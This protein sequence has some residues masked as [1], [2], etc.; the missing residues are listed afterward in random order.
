MLFY[1]QRKTYKM[2]KV[3]IKPGLPEQ[4]SEEQR[5]SRRKLWRALVVLLFFILMTAGVIFL[6]FSM[7]KAFF[8]HNRHFKLKKLE[9]INGSF[10]HGKEKSL[11]YRT[12]VYP[13]VNLFSVDYA[14]FRKRIESIS[15]IEKAEV[16]RILPDKLQVKITE[17]I[18][19]AVL[20]TPAGR[21]VVDEQAVVIPRAESAVHGTLPV[22]TSVPGRR[23]VRQGETLETLRPAIE[24]IM[25]TLRNFP[26][27]DIEC[28]MP[29][30]S[31]G[32]TFFMRYRSGKRYHVTLPLNSKG[33]PYLLSALQT[34]IINIHW[35]QLN[36]SR[37]NLLY[38]GRV[39][40]N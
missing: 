19:R 6:F 26:D 28:I 13:G 21:F 22:I 20:F 7:R 10:W 33:L 8:S 14:S 23:I 4:R 9:I 24:L 30:D 40:L 31:E 38:D 32:L 37:I 27:I 18:P 11:S 39:V 29:G 1:T 15:G 34:A 36:V 17:R 16:V 35:K 3:K 12:G 5:L 25:M 2:A